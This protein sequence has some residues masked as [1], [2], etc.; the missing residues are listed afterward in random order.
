MPFSFAVL[1]CE[2]EAPKVSVRGWRKLP[3]DRTARMAAFATRAPLPLRQ[4]KTHGG[5]GIR[6][7]RPREIAARE[8][9]STRDAKH[10]RHPPA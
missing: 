8:G 5:N 6:I 10:R 2:S 7:T 4:S 9:R 1:E 3:D